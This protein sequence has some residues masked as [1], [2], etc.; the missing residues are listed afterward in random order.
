MGS[1]KQ[2]RCR[3]FP[4][5]HAMRKRAKNYRE[6]AGGIK[7]AV[8]LIAERLHFSSPRMQAAPTERLTRRHDW[9]Y[10]LRTERRPDEQKAESF[11]TVRTEDQYRHHD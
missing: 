8:V 2:W 3:T 9:K 1:K 7:H 4:Q 11:Q 5:C 10:G 6:D